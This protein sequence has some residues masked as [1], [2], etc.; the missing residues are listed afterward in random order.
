MVASNAWWNK[1]ALQEVFTKGLNDVVEDE[2]PSREDL[3][4]LTDL[5]PC[6]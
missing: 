4:D 3:T 5:F 2:V 6:P 1:E